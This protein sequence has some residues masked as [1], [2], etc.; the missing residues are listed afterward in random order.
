MTLLGAALWMMG[1]HLASQWVT[2]IV[3]WLFG[4]VHDLMI[5]IVCQAVGYLLVLYAMLRVHAPKSRIRDFVGLR[6]TSI[7]FVV[8]A[9]IVGV[10]AQYPGSFAQEHLMRWFPSESADLG[11][12]DVFFGLTF[13]RRVAIATAATLLGPIAEELIFRGAAFTSILAR[14]RAMAV[15]VVTS[16]GFAV[17]HPD[18]R[19]VPILLVMG[20][21][22]GHLRW[23]SGSL[24][25]P[26]LLHVAFNA[27]PFAYLLPVDSMP[28]DERTPLLHALVGLA[29]VVACVAASHVL[30]R[31]SRAV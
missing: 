28:P 17:I 27:V 26:I 20:L 7:A 11:F 10:A 1:A 29:A 9:P 31:R 18:L 23:A 15:V 8:M 12:L 24:L 6:P 2:L 13:P 3:M 19:D 16:V 5:L 25:P 4:R 22:L 21:I 14:H 30:G